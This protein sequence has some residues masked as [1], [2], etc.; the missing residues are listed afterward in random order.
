MTNALKELPISWDA[1]ARDTAE[2]LSAARRV[3]SYRSFLN[4]ARAAKVARRAPDIDRQVHAEARSVQAEGVLAGAAA[5]RV[6]RSLHAGGAFTHIVDSLARSL[7][8]G[9]PVEGADLWL[10]IRE[11][12]AFRPYLARHGID[13]AFLEEFGGLLDRI[14]L[15]AS[16]DGAAITVEG[17]VDGKAAS[18]RMACHRSTGLPRDPIDLMTSGRFVAVCDALERGE[19]AFLLGL[20][21]RREMFFPEEL[22]MAAVLADQR[23]SIRHVRKLEDVGLVTQ[24]GGD[25]ITIVTVIAVA[26]ILT[27]III[28]AIECDRDSLGLN[29]P[30][31]G[32]KIGHIMATL[33][34][35]VLLI[36]TAH[37]GVPVS[38]TG[39]TISG[40]LPQLEGT[41][42]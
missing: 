32:C 38:T 3:R 15:S 5:A 23:E 37:S 24:A 18:A 40:P 31:I 12:G 29:D 35:V 21:P 34:F 33:G 17:S 19:S 30:D 22:L 8:T 39:Q 28:S 20:G 14:D 10:Q 42:T 26:L 13:D 16:S 25:V 4:R 41:P 9:G 2:V 36:I 7:N 6:L 1:V 11:N 27:G